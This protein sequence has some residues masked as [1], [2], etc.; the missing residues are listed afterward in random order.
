MS[1]ADIAYLYG[2]NIPYRIQAFVLSFF[3][4]C[5]LFVGKKKFGKIRFDNLLQVRVM[6]KMLLSLFIY[7]DIY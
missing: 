6:L 2:A 5:Y 7:P 4:I 3:I 1:N